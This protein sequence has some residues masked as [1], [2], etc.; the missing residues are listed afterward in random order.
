MERADQKCFPI[1]KVRGHRCKKRVGLRFSI[2]E[3]LSP[4]PLS[5]MSD[6]EIEFL[7]LLSWML[8]GQFS[9]PSKTCSLNAMCVFSYI[10]H[11]AM[12]GCHIKKQDLIHGEWLLS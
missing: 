11:F 10:R 1:K 3:L 8:S 12:Y 4:V 2:L 9:F 7:K 6:L 5:S